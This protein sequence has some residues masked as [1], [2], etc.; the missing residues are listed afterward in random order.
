MGSPT[1]PTA[2]PQDR[3]RLVVQVLLVAAVVPQSRA[4]ARRTARPLEYPLPASSELREVVAFLGDIKYEYR[5]WWKGD[6]V[7]SNP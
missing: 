6:R 3:D 4:A 7:V 2:Q 1:P 5:Y